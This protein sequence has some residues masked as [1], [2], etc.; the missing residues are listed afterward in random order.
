MYDRYY[1]TCR[2]VQ[3]ADDGPR[4]SAQREK[5]KAGGDVHFGLSVMSLITP[6]LLRSIPPASA[7][8]MCLIN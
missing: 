6:H 1:S 8:C 7:N 5:M 3:A 2:D 4:M